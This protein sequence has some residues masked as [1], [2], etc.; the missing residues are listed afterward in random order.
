MIYAEFL[1]INYGKICSIRQIFPKS[2]TFVREQLETKTLC[3]NAF[4]P[5]FKKIKPSY[6]VIQ[7]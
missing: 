3:L 5:N 2:I 4:R 1:K 7:L 6:G